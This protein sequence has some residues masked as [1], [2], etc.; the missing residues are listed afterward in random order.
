MNKHVLFIH[1]AG[2]GAY[3]LAGD[4]YGPL[5]DPSVFA[6]VEIDPEVHTL[7]WPNGADFDPAISSMTGLDMRRACGIWLRG[8][9][10]RRCSGRR[11]LHYGA[12]RG[13]SIP[14]HDAT[15]PATSRLRTMPALPLE[16]PAPMAM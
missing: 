10:W 6:S 11:T 4:I 14:S 15:L 9:L 2:E 3:V 5:H 16:T 1:G 8:G 7:V 12:G 13:F